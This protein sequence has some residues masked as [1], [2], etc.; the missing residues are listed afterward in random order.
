MKRP[1][2]TLFSILITLVGCKDPIPAPDA[3]ILVAPEDNISCL[4]VPLNT[5]T[6]NVLFSWQQALNTDD[7]VLKVRSEATGIETTTPTENTSLRLTLDRGE[8][9]GWKVVSRSE[10]SAEETESNTRYF[11]LEAQQ[12]LAHL[13][14]PAKLVSPEEEEV[15][16]LNN[17]NVEFS[18]EGADLDSDISSYNI[19][20]GSTETSL[21]T[22]ASGLTQSSYSYAVEMGNQYYWQVETI[23]R[24]GNRSSSLISYFQTAP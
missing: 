18:W 6:A 1:Y 20:L 12:Q 7:Y 22:I 16:E 23:D 19:L 9:Y 15:V 24:E 14:F 2:S 10:A 13:P 8:V 17:G 21:E 3:A 5:A 11:F 4:Y